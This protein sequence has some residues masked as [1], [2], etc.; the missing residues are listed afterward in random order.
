L[1]ELATAFLLADTCLLPA[2]LSHGPV[3]FSAPIIENHTPNTPLVSLSS[4]QREAI[5]LA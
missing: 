5:L 4:S 2:I 3:Q 1:G